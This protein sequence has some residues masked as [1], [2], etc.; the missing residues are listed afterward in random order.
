MVRRTLLVL[1]SICTLL[2]S[3]V[4]AQEQRTPIL[5]GSVAV[6]ATGYVTYTVKVDAA[7]MVNPR[8]VGHVQAT[9]GSGNDIEVV[10]FTETQFI[11]WKNSHKQGSLFTSGQITASDVDVPL[12]GS[13]TYYVM[14]SNVFSAFTPKTVE[15]NLAL[16][17]TTPP[18]PPPST[19]EQNAQ[20]TLIGT[21]IAVIVGVLVFA[22]AIGGLIVWLVMSR[23]KKAVPGGPA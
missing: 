8:I 15:G 18:P 11:N 6:E 1:A 23:K 12:D 17:W 2:P 5:N 10:V 20:N 7:S 4:T 13:G 21:G 19:E 14:L 16:V 22:G 3:P 9:G